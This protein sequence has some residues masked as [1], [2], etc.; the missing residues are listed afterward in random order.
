MYLKIDYP[1]VVSKA[2]SILD[3]AD[4]LKAQLQV[5]N[6]LEQECRLGWQGEAASEFLARLDSLRN[7][8]ARTQNSMI[9]LAE[10]I[11]SAAYEID[12]SETNLLDILKTSVPN[13][14][15]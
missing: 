10:V 12:K 9:E 11:K 2:N 7:E 6:S 8:I 5:L 3:N 15:N 4:Q 14:S 13:G 1:K